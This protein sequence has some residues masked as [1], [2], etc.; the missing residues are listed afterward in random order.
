MRKW[1][2]GEPSR[3][4]TSPSELAHVPV[5]AR[6]VLVL[7]F[8][9]HVGGLRQVAHEDDGVHPHVPHEVRGDIGEIERRILAQENDVEL[10]EIAALGIAKL[11]M[12]FFLVAH[13]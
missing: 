1:K 4:S 13:A 2:A 5:G 6:L 10:R 7:L 3:V 12:I 11:E 9:E 8:G